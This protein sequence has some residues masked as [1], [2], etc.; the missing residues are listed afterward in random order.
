M[1]LTW[2]KKDHRL[3]YAEWPAYLLDLY[4]IFPRLLFV[5]ATYVVYEMGLWYMFTLQSAERT[6]EVTAFVTVVTGAWVK[7]LD[8]YMQR[9][10][11]W[12]KRMQINGGEGGN[13]GTTTGT[14]PSGS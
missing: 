8:Y 13:N 14:G 2:L 12:S 5:G 3:N 11:D 4:R 1:K 7:A 10:T 9:G 6:A